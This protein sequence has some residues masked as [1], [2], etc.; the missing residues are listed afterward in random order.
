VLRSVFLAAVVA[1]L[2]AGCSPANRP[3]V[4]VGS[5]S[6]TVG[7]YETAA[8]GAETQ[9][10]GL[11]DAAKAQLVQDLVSRAAMLEMAHQLGHDQAAV[12]VN[13][14]RDNERRALVQ[15]LFARIASPAQPV[16]ESEARAL[17][18]ARKQE[19]QVSMI[20]TSSRESALAAQARLNAGAPFTEVARSLSLPGV[21]PPSGEMGV[22][23]PGSLPDPLDGAIREQKVGMV[24]G[25][26]ETR[27]GWFLVKIT[28]RRPHEQGSWEAL[29]AG[30]L[31]L[32]RQ[33][34]QRAAF[35]R[36]YQD[37]KAEWQMQPAPGGSQLLFH[38][39]SPVDP[40]RPTP[41][42]RRMPLA[43]YAGGTYTLQD[44]LTDMLD[45]SVQRPPSQLL[46]AVEIWIETQTMTRIAVLEAR[47]RHLHEEPELVSV[48]RRK[49]ED[50][51]L[52]GIYQNAVAAVPP[53][54]PAL[55]RLAWEQL[56]GRFTRLG[57][58][59]LASV[60]VPDSSTLLKLVRVGATTRSLAEAVKQVDAPLTVR[61]TTVHYPNNDP[62]W[63]ALVAMFSQMQP[64]A[65]Y[66][67][68]PLAHGWRI[69]Q[70]V[71][72]TMLQQ[73]FDEL[74]PAMQQNIA[75]SAAELARDARFR[76]FSDSLKRAYLPVVDRRL[77]AKLPW[78]VRAQVA[79]ER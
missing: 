67:P 76:Q 47:R 55:V 66:G 4:R 77:L 54:G 44:A 49:H 79:P 9:Y 69:L 43:T 3:L 73:T 46:P 22:I 71:D 1:L 37:L 33:R 5:Q 11:P 35:N 23:L 19:A 21:L 62:G 31:E 52:E 20:Y 27:E 39:L 6:V 8:R 18:E 26:F 72:K 58:V 61:D 12:V 51:L 10:P 14:D 30:M 64:G 57:D 17:Y 13:S 60:V 32:E 50:M 75:G 38:V 45:V 24:G 16:S 15:A 36:A 34:K 42:Q 56:K 70:M 53:P 7:D 74:A 48:L 29:R 78:P 28:S 25:P 41:E 2:L 63:N 59:R 65:W 68:E 40:L